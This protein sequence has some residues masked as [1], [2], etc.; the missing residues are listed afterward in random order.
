MINKAEVFSAP[1]WCYYMVL[2]CWILHGNVLLM[3]G[4]FI[5]SICWVKLCE[6]CKNFSLV[7]YNTLL[8]QLPTYIWVKEQRKSLLWQ[9]NAM[10][11]YSHWV[12]HIAYSTWQLIYEC[13]PTK[14]E[15]WFSSPSVHIGTPPFMVLA[16][17]IVQLKAN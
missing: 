4:I 12:K 8:L 1:L 13:I 16:L 14:I 7:Y 5:W 11:C 3:H 17:K 9:I 2:C 15:T 6:D 10:S